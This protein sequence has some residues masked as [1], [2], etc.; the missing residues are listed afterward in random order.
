MDVAPWNRASVADVV[1]SVDLVGAVVG[2][3]ASVISSVG[4]HLGH[5]CPAF[6]DANH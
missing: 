1:N 5:C 6:V 2:T 3:P 4:P